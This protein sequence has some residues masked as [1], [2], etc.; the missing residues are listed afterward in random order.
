MSM[1]T[2]MTSV[3]ILLVRAVVK[4]SNKSEHLQN[5]VRSSG[6]GGIRRAWPDPEL[7]SPSLVA[8]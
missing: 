8:C 7:F 1:Y 2:S 4:G 3:V 6:I 5:L